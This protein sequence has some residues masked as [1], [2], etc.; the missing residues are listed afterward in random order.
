MSATAPVLESFG[1]PVSWARES[2]VHEVSWSIARMLRIVVVSASDTPTRWMEIHFS[3]ARAAK[4]LD[5]GDVQGFLEPWPRDSVL[6]RVVAGGWVA[7]SD[8]RLFNLWRAERICTEWAVVTRD[9][10][11]FVLSN[12]TPFVREYWS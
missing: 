2:D 7:N 10:C 11:V 3:Y 4:V 6:H 8:P 5:E 9:T 12:E 1:P